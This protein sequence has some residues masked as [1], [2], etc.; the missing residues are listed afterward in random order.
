[1]RDNLDAILAVA[2]VVVASLG[3]GLVLEGAMSSTAATT[4]LA[5]A[6]LFSTATAWIRPGE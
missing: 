3:S 5:L 2:V 4:A 1:M 6:L